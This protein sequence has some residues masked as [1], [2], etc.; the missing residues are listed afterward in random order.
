MLSAV[1]QLQTEYQL[2]RQRAAKSQKRHD[3]TYQENTIR[4][5][6]VKPGRQ[7]AIDIVPRT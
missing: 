7:R 4:F 3:M 6:Q 1:T 2:S 5:D